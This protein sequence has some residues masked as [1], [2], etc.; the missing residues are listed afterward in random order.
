MERGRVKSGVV[1]CLGGRDRARGSH[2]RATRCYQEEGF[3]QMNLGP[4]RG[5]IV[6]TGGRRRPARGSLTLEDNVRSIE[7]DARGAS[8]PGASQH[9]AS[10]HGASQHEASQHEASQHEASQHGAS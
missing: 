10:Q 6:T 8:Q 7:P 3:N 1:G 4:G 2:M 9:G 5:T